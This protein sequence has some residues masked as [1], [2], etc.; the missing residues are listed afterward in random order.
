MLGH[1]L[2]EAGIGHEV[3]RGAEE[4]EQ[5]RGL[6]GKTSERRTWRQIA[7]LRWTVSTRCGREAT[8]APLMAPAEVPTIRSG[9]MSRS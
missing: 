7:A 2:P 9:A 4:A 3:S 1:E 6:R 8:Y 5:A